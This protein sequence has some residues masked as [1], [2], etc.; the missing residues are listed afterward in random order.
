[1][2]MFHAVSSVLPSCTTRRG[3]E[4]SVLRKGLVAGFLYA[5]NDLQ[6]FCRLEGVMKAIS[7]VQK[8]SVM[9]YSSFGS[10][11]AKYAGCQ[12]YNNVARGLGG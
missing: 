12:K 3:I 4:Q 1:M 9:S 10:R 11:Y 8:G 6:V 2:R 5:P 7:S